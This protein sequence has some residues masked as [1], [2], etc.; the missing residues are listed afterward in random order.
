MTLIPTTTKQTTRKLFVVAAA[1]LAFTACVDLAQRWE[2]DHARILA[3]KLDAPMLAAGNSA[4]ITGIVVDDL[5][6]ASE[7]A[8][9]GALLIS[10]EPELANTIAIEPGTWKITAGSAGSIAAARAALKVPADQPL[11]LQIGARFVFAGG[12]KDAIKE[13]AIGEVAPG[14]PPVVNPVTPT[15]LVDGQPFTAATTLALGATAKFSLGNAAEL[16]DPD[17]VFQWSVSTGDMTKSETIAAT[18]ELLS[19]SKTGPANLVVVIRSK[20]GGV[21]WASAQFQVTP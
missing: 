5:G 17:L 9:V 10:P 3:V 18:I 1:A 8:P 12:T 2:L 13:I 4:N 7:I 20:T 16:A 21:S 15:L 19:T 6:V 11:R 14:M